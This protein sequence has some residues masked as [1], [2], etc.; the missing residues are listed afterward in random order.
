V[1]QH[2]AVTF[3]AIFL[4][5]LP[6]K[7]MIAT[8]LLSTHFHRRL[9][10]W[11][12]VTLGYA[13]HVM[14]AVIFGTALSQ[15]PK[16]PIHVLVGLLFLT[17]GVM[18]WRAGS[19]ADHDETAKWSASMSNAR[20]VWTAASVILVAEFGDLTQLATAGFAARFDDPIAVG[21]GSIAA[22]SSVS[23]LAVLAGGWLQKKVPLNKIQRAAAV[24]FAL[25]GIVTLVS[26][27][28]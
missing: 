22:L 18:T 20:V 19:S 7:T 4:A 25:I 24:L 3:S 13:I 17:G 26:A 21:F 6:D 1:L 5:E 14:L 23:G 16:T 10:V 27:A 28:V 12:G 9:P 8:L 11:A 2:F 15:L